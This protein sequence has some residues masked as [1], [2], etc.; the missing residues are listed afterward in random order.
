MYLHTARAYK[1]HYITACKTVKVPAM[2]V[3]CGT[4]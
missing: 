2:S 4:T 1:H 3:K